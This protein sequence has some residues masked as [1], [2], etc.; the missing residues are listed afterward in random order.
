MLSDD[1]VVSVA[2]NNDKTYPTDLVLAT[3]QERYEKAVG[4]GKNVLVTSNVERQTKEQFPGQVQIIDYQ[5]WTKTEDGVND[6]AIVIMFNILQA[7]GAK[8]IYLAGFDGF[9]SNINENY[10]DPNLRRPVTEEQA[11]ERNRFV[12]KFL[13]KMREGMKL[14]FLTESKYEERQ[15][16]V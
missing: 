11:N 10:M 6:S 16:L 14:C 8:E 3:K 1:T 7:V 5:E 12:R 4:R 2:L 15:T 13:G 9:S